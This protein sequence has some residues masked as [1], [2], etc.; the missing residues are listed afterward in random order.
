MLDLLWAAFIYCINTRLSDLWVLLMFV[1][2]LLFTHDTGPIKG[3]S[4]IIYCTMISEMNLLL[5]VDQ[6]WN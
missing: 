5:E 3:T 4:V 6:N 2:L 1:L